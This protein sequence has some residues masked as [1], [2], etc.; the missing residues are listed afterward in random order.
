MKA[1][2][3][4]ENGLP[5]QHESEEFP[6]GQST[7]SGLT[8]PSPISGLLH[9]TLLA[10]SDL[11]CTYIYMII[12]WGS[13]AVSYLVSFHRGGFGPHDTKFSVRY[14]VKYVGILFRLKV[15]L[16]NRIFVIPYRC[17]SHVSHF[18]TAT[19]LPPCQQ[20]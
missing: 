3:R 15:S 1:S 18:P 8:V 5:H 16:L 4:L 13:C 6:F 19:L 17:H 12:P 7:R 20:Q 11:T 14:F 2:I 10:P 9:I